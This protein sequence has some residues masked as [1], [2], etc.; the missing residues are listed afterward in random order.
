[1]KKLYDNDDD[2]M[3]IDNTLDLGPPPSNYDTPPPEHGNV[4]RLT[5]DYEV[6][7]IYCVA[8]P[9]DSHK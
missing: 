2:Y 6:A 3:E 7:G 5:P 9:I 8:V 1:M 4:D